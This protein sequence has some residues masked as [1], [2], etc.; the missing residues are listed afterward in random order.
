MNQNNP[1]NLNNLK[2]ETQY[3]QYSWDEKNPLLNKSD[4]F[5]FKIKDKDFRHY[6]NTISEKNN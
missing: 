3:K 2:F 1:N 5:G 6:N 4:K